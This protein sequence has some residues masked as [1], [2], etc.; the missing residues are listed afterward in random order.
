MTLS[1][2]AVRTWLR[3]VVLPLGLTLVGLVL[4]ATGAFAAGGSM[5]NG[6]SYT[7]TVT[8]GQVDQWT[9]SANKG[10]ALVVTASEVGT[11]TGFWPYVQVQAPDGTIVGSGTSDVVARVD[12]SA[13]QTGTYTARVSRYYAND[14]GGQYVVTL[15]QAPE[16]FTVPSGDEGGPMSNGGT[17]TGSLARG[18]VD[19]WSFTASKGNAITLTASEVG[20]NTSF[21]PYLQV[22]GPSGTHMASGTNTLEARVD[23]SAPESGTYTVF[24]SRY[25]QTDDSGKYSLA[26]AGAGAPGPAPTTVPQAAAPA[27]APPVVNVPQATPTT[28]PSPTATPAVV[29][30]AV[31][32]PQAPAPTPTHDTSGS[33]SPVRAVQ[34]SD[35][36]FLLIQGV[37]AWVLFPI[38]LADS[39]LASLSVNN[40]LHGILI[41]V[42]PGPAQVAQGGDTTLYLVQGQQAAVLVPDQIADTDASALNLSGEVDGTLPDQLVAAAQVQAATTPP[43]PVA[44]SAPPA[45]VDAGPPPTPVD[46]SPPPA[47]PSNPPSVQAVPD[48]LT[49]DARSDILAAVDRANTGWQTARATLD[50]SALSDAVAGLELRNDLTEVDKLR[51]QG[52]TERSTNIAFTVNGVTMDG[53]GHATVHTT[54]TWSAE[55]GALLGGRVVQRIPPTTYSETY[56]LEYLDGRWIVTLNELH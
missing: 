13:A 35:G 45:P 14:A 48:T 46:A 41:I 12:L 32:P 7:G 11:N 23:F 16:A 30:D 43:A 42:L 37:N 25:Y 33:P 49:D 52:Y 44:T 1:S 55:I 29:S 47:P 53:P 8:R 10:D 56:T 24:V 34:K 36:S 28:A 40:A 26:L 3:F 22:Y 6:G 50:T 31:Q 17:Y 4:S 20:T 19:V 38:Q 5:T 27:P 51:N 21:W 39:D 15:A 18:D 54:E 2:P 9:F